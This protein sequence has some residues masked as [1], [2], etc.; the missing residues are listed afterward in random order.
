M[1]PRIR[2]NGVEYESV[3]AMPPDV[4]EAFQSLVNAWPGGV[5][6]LL[7]GKG[8]PQPQNTYVVGG[9][10]YP[11]VE[12][13]PPEVR[14]AVEQV[15]ADKDR[16]GVP[17]VLQQ[18][19]KQAVV[20]T[21]TYTVDGRSFTSLDEMPADV[22]RT[23]DGLGLLG[24]GVRAGGAPASASQGSE[25]G[26]PAP[27]A[28]GARASRPQV[29]AREHEWGEVRPRRSALPWILVVLLAGAVAALLLR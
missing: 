8:R 23:L 5:A 16:D 19:T 3:E 18:G 7:Q 6:D 12:A 25:G 24:D 2:F 10:S 29:R 1:G 4:R 21:T 22:R 20:T 17:D 9:Q 15:L 14:R 13:L 27:R 11:S 26:G 28:A